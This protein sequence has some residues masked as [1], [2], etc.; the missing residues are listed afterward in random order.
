[1]AP[2]RGLVLPPAQGADARQRAGDKGPAASCPR[3]G[4]QARAGHGSVPARGCR[5]PDLPCLPCPSVHPAPVLAGMAGAQLGTR[6]AN[7][8]TGAVLPLP[9]AL[10]LHCSGVALLQLCPS[11][12]AA[13][14]KWGAVG[15]RAMG[16]E[17]KAQMGPQQR[18]ANITHVARVPLCLSFPSCYWGPCECSMFPHHSPSRGCLCPHSPQLVAISLSGGSCHWC[19]RVQLGLCPP[20][21][22]RGAL[23]HDAKWCRSPRGRD[24]TWPQL[25][26]TQVGGTGTD[27]PL[28]MGDAGSR[29]AE[30]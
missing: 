19:C 4:A 20:T 6:W 14:L 26:G 11:Q 1:M 30:S 3:E 24:W 21:E 8:G 27:S 28:S 25:K 7:P 5:C 12:D 9:W 29:E 18:V 2:I 15:H 13:G 10:C 16:R 22:S 23:G 17:Q